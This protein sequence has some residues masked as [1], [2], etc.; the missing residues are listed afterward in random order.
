[1]NEAFAE[2]QAG[3]FDCAFRL[4]K[5]L[6]E[7]GTPE[8]QSL[9]GSLYQLGL[10]TTVDRGEAMRWYRAASDQGVGVAS[11]NL[12]G[13]L[14]L[15]GRHSEAERFYELA[16]QQDFVHAPQKTAPEGAEIPA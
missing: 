6:A 3:R 13:M 7:Q 9:L 12:A 5:P 10:G 2:Y 16:R 4:L 1:M 14:E 15:D 8:A 11:N